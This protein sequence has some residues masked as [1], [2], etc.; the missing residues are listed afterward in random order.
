M[1][2]VNKMPVR[3]CHRQRSP[4]RSSLSCQDRKRGSTRRIAVGI[5]PRR[6]CAHW[7]PPGWPSGAAR[8]RPGQDELLFASFA[9][10][11]IQ[12]VISTKGIFAVRA[13]IQ[14]AAGWEAGRRSPGGH[15]RR[16]SLGGGAGPWAS[17]TP[18][19]GRQS[20]GGARNIAHDDRVS[21]LQTFSSFA[22]VGVS[23]SRLQA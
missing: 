6:R 15:T 14:T 10:H 21:R 1:F 11:A 9:K 13:F 22:M 12:I 16:P 7:L 5:F 4:S 23:V 8:C 20:R 18:P 3:R 17:D 19:S 2:G